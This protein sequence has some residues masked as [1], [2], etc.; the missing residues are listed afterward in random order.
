[1]PS[2]RDL[3][4]QARY[5]RDLRAQKRAAGRKQLNATVKGDLVARLDSL[6]AARGLTNRDDALEQVLEEYF[7]EH[8]ETKGTLP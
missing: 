1:M 7:V 5:Q 4:Y 3:E 8:G 6:K 2:A